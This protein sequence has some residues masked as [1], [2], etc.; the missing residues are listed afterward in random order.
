MEAIGLL[1]GGIAHDFNNLLQS[2]IMGIAI[3]QTRSHEDNVRGVLMQTADQCLKAEE[4]SNL[5]V[6]FSKGGTP[7]IQKSPIAD[8]LQETVRLVLKGSP[9][10][11][12][13]AISD[14][15]W[16]VEIDEGQIR[17]AINQL[18]MNAKEAMPSGG[19]LK[20]QV[21]NLESIAKENVP[22]AEGK[23]VKITF[24]DNGAGISPENLSKIFDPYFTTKEMGSQKGMGLSLTV[25]Q[26]IIKKHNGIITAESKAGEGTMFHMYLPAAEEK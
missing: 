15:L 4:L 2:I 25:S 11:T 21:R 18:V 1:A 26:S 19:L 12:E 5:L 14:D 20:I 10:N 6:T 22:L 9:V 16:P 7:V 13:F 8:L 23:Y 17:T 3:A 24:A